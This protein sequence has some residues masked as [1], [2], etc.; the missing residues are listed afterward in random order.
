[1]NQSI[2]QGVGSD[3]ICLQELWIAEQEMVDLY[4]RYVWAWSVKM[5]VIQVFHT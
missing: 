5:V 2:R 4:Q 3:V 1:M